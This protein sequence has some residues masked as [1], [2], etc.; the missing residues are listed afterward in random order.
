[1][2][3]SN[4]LSKPPTKEYVQ[5]IEAMGKLQWDISGGNSDV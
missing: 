3:L 5:V 1:M 2:R 4:L